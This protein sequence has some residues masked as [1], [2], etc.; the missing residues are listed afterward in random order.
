MQRRRDHVATSPFSHRLRPWAVAV[1]L[2]AAVAFGVIEATR[3]VIENG[4]TSELA[5]EAERRAIEIMAVTL[6]G[7][8]MG[9]VAGMGLVSQPVKKV[10]RGEIALDDPQVTDMLRALGES[11]KATGLYVVNSTGIV[12]SGWYSIGV[13]LVGVNVNFRPYFQIAMRGK[14]NVYAAIGTTTGQRALYVAAP[15]YDAVSSSS[16]IIGATV[17]RLDVERVDTA[18]KSWRG[19]ALLLSPQQITFASNR[20]EWIERMAQTTTPE[21]IKAIRALKQFGNTFEVGVPKSLPF[22]LT[23]K[24]VR[25]DNRR[26]AVS[27][28]SVH[29]NDPNGEWTLV[30][31]SDLDQ[32]MPIASRIEIGVAISALMLLLCGVFLVWRQ[33]LEHANLDRLRAEVEVKSHASKLEL[34]SETKTYLANV[35]ADLHQAGSLADFARKFLF[36][37]VPK[38]AADFGLFYIY[39]QDSLQLIPVG[40][41][42]IAN[43]GLEKMA[44]GQ[45]LV[46]QC[47]KDMAPIVISDVGET[48]I[49]IVSGEGAISP[50]SIVLLPLVQGDQLLGVILVAALRIITAEKRALLDALLPTVV[51]N[52]QILERSLS[53]QRQA[54]TLQKQQMRLQETEAWYRGIIKSAP[55]GLLVADE[56]GVITL[57]NPQIEAMFGYDAGALIGQKVEVLVPPAIRPHHPSLREGFLR[58]SRTRAMGALAQDLRGVR[59]DGS[60][61][62]VEVSLSTLPA[63]DGSSLCVCASVRDISERKRAQE[64]LKQALSRQKAILDTSP[65]GI[66][67]AENECFALLNPTAERI[68]GYAPGELLGKPIRVVFASDREYQDHMRNAQETLARGE[69]FVAERAITRKDGVRRRIRDTAA[70][71]DPLDFSK[72]LLMI[73]EDIT[74]AYEA[75]EVLRTATERLDLAQEAGNVGIFD[76]VVDGRNYWTP[77]LERMFGLEPGGFGGTVEEWAARLHPEDRER[78]LRGFD[79]A[80][81]SE[82]SS[83][84]DEFRVVRPDG[85][86]R[87]FQSI[88][89]ILRTPEGRA[90]RAVGVNIDLTDIVNARKI[91]EEATQAKS[92]FLANMSHEIRTPMNAVIGLSHLALKTELTRQ[93][94]DYVAKI[95]QSGQH[96]LGI[97]NDVLDFSKI[98]AGKLDVE[99]VD[100]DLDTVL[101]NVANLIGDKAGAKGL[102]LVF[103]VAPDVPTA[104]IGDPLRI[105][106]VL[107]N[108]SNNAVK[109]TERGEIDIVVRARKREESADEVVIYFGVRDTG[110]GL[111]PAQKEKLFQSFQQADNSTTRKYGGTGLGLAISK[112]LAELMGGTVGVD[113][114]HGKGSTFWFTARL[115]KGQAK[116]KILLPAVDLR[117]RRVLVVDDNDNARTVLSDMLG[118]MTFEVTTESSGQAAIEVVA[119]A[120]RSGNPFEI[121][122]LDWQMPEMDGIET[123]R[124]LRKLR[125]TKTPHLI[126]V[127]A[128]GREEVIKG[129]Q[130]AGIEDVLLKPVSPSLL[131]DSAIRILGGKMHEE[132]SS[133]AGSSRITD[134]LAMIKGA[135][136]LLVEDNEINQEIAVGL[137]AEGGFVIDVAD[138]GEIAVKKVQEKTYDLVLMD[139]QMPVMDGVTATREIRK[140]PQLAKLPI[141]AMTANVMA[142]DREQCAAA[143]MNDHVGKPIDPY[144]LFAALQK[145]I[146]ARE[147]GTDNEVLSMATRPLAQANTSGDALDLIEGLDIKAGLRRVLNKRTSYENLLRRFIDGQAN[148]VSL[149]RNQ[150]EAG[151]HE[152]AQ[153]TAHTLKGVSGT[154]GAG[155]LQE[156]AAVVEHAVKAG[157]GASDIEAALIDV[158]EELDRLISAISAA[159][160]K[161]Q[162]AAIAAEVDWAEAK[163]IVT[164]LEALLAND[165]SEA[166]ELFNE[167][168]ALLRAACGSVATGIERDLARFMFVDALSALRAA[169]SS[170]PQLN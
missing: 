63:L 69:T 27:R 1:L 88:C 7:N 168:S 149:I 153:R 29:W 104:L 61:F 83:F 12:Q 106:Q 23:G 78:A 167:H 32:L 97:I 129:A 118:S 141:L 80:L 21:Q 20:G 56:Q 71:F 74:E 37:T 84:A 132:R 91:A 6:N 89:R 159:L 79:E 68:F 128:H 65:V 134:N 43:D 158:R 136:I 70:A 45:G 35:S 99:R 72:G 5:I 156:R 125:M 117:G 96:L 166:V 11:Y 138:N 40:G 77:Q 170:I 49:Q 2:S 58:S 105:G 101:Q 55:E 54:E 157:Q 81:R 111:T 126:M 114:E 22:D 140:L 109:F 26:Y 75:A 110:I 127:T 39:D 34:E 162:E 47:A 82:L 57:A 98:E 14:Q 3:L 8:V 19:P 164:R 131:F 90:Q 13:N 24:T 48:D 151:Q 123:A 169:K 15:L 160:P 51:M 122:F 94:R 143:G 42:G 85:S 53:T 76:V 30:L 93:Q 120:S 130:D 36:H 103:D 44:V 100:F 52:L 64:T 148:A 121:I 155:L 133:Q 41:Y 146:P 66:V 119:T 152:D 107:I 16:P 145:W 38:V 87:W 154:I 124:E 165:D 31:L 142:A 112:K 92:M 60:E 18:L 95:Q 137:L 62:P 28:A 9:A 150:L 73:K 17:M 10:V 113:S 102:E 108:Y 33:R 135:R 161:E 59:R 116:K 163:I 4:H 50:K 147:P 25:F 86:V 144:E 115:G 67:V 46:G 139:M